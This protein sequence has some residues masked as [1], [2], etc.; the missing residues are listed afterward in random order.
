MAF[1]VGE[2]SGA[3]SR[4]RGRTT[5]SEINVVPFVDILLVLLIIFM[6]TAN[7]MEFGLEVEVPEVGTARQS[8]EDL[9]VVNIT[10]SGEVYLGS[11]PVNINQLGPEIKRRHAG[12]KNVY[13]RADTNAVWGPI[14][15]VIHELDQAKL[16]VR[17][18]TKPID[19]A[20][21]GR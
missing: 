12:K 13:V 7:V 8:N 20:K 21:R 1:S 6:I 4:F 10:R 17:M 15:Q 9:P 19:T 14:A 11:N 3:R 5:L 18:V 16:G 2:S